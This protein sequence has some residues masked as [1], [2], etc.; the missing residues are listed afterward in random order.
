MR[1]VEVDGQEMR[2]EDSGNEN[3]GQE[4]NRDR[5]RKTQERNMKGMSKKRGCK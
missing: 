3:T 4:V 1:L 2:R 5:K